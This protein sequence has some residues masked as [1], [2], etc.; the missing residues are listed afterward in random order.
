MADLHAGLAKRSRTLN[1]NIVAVID[2]NEDPAGVE[3]MLAGPP[4]E[5]VLL[6]TDHPQIK[7]L[8]SQKLPPSASII[9][10]DAMGL[11]SGVTRLV[12][13]NRALAAD[14][15]RLKETRLRLHQFV[16]TA[17]MA[18]YIKD[19]NLRY[20]RM[21]SHSLHLLGLKEKDVV[22][23]TD[24]SI[25]PQGSALWLQNIELETLR[26]GHTLHASG[27]LPVM[28]EE[29]HV[30][31]TLFPL[32]ENGRTDGL[33]GFLEDT[34]ELFE[35]EQKLHRVDEQLN[36]T[37]H[38]LRGVLESSR[39]MIFLTDLEGNLLSFNTG[40]EHSLGFSRD[41]VVGLPA[42][43]LCSTPSNFDR[44]FQSTLKTGHAEQF[45]AEF[46]GTNGRLV[47]ANISL[48]LIDGPDG[49]LEVVCL[50]RDITTRL[51][52][53]NDLI[54]SERLAAI[55]QMA[56]GVAHE[57][58]NPMAVI[59]TI[60]GLVEETLID[61]GEALNN[62]TRFMLGKAMERLHH[63]VKRVTTITHS[64]L[65]FV[66]NSQ[67]GMAAINLESLIEESLNVLA[68]EIRRSH[69][70]IIKEY[71]DNLPEFNSDPSLLQ[72]V[73]VNLISNAIDAIGES[74]KPSG[75]LEIATRRDGNQ[76]VI[77]FQDNGTGIPKD[78]RDRI[79]DLFH[80][81]KP[82]GKG[83]GL[84]LSIVH[85]IVHRLGGSIRVA[86]EVEHWTRFTIR[87]PLTPP[88]T[89]LPDLTL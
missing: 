51:R 1:L 26:S 46:R 84:G 36:E 65:G 61:E 75:L 55:G 39:D 2:L 29:M 69:A 22:G 63:Q 42:H 35:S 81:T 14:S 13:K 74:G 6:C 43:N 19:E 23:K 60:A 15:R 44:L 56:A 64:M 3:K 67:G 78:A 83:T 80:T 71:S 53:K 58:N 31:V 24:Q 59:D 10:P 4:P 11:F 9:G 52:L 57:I 89:L 41:D 37:Q 68:S 20:R 12:D 70:E 8:L 16:E 38:Y 17:N 82:V 86:S 49:P 21:N 87:L 85:D 34:T 7:E 30:T 45:E 32:V 18:I 73:F 77:M 66:H 76:A 5:L 48:T 40:A 54:R 79:F 27:V 33:Y 28:G 50:C 72:Q 62:E 47:I 25:Y 88:D